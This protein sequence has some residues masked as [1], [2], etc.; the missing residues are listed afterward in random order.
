MCRN[1]R[2][3]FN[4]APPATEDE[5][6]AASLQYR[7]KDQRL[8]Q[9]VSGKRGRLSDRCRRDCPHLGATPARP[10]VSCESRRIGRMRW[11]RRRRAP[12]SDLP[13]ECDH[14][15]ATEP[16]RGSDRADPPAGGRGLPRRVAPRLRHADPPARRLRPRRGGA[17]RCLRCRAGAMAA[18]RRAGQSARLARFDRPV[19]GHRRH[20]PARPVRRLAA[21]PRRASSTT[22]PTNAAE[23]GRRG[24][25]GRPAAA[26]LHLLPSRA[27]AGGAG[28]ADAAGG[29]RPHDR[30]DRARVPDR[31][32]HAGPA[33]RARQG[34]DPR[35]AAFPTRCRR[36]PTCPSGWTRCCT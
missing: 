18:G 11:P 35:R 12:R 3:L 6:R 2:T 16:D 21:E 31:A 8:Q 36:R 22:T 19:Q 32:A 25:R 24:R 4:F 33:H 26:D 1:I 7:Q 15:P 9:T 34:E 20:A 14:D 10:R 17:A 29:L 5:I 30:G 28:R 13:H 23:S 27:A